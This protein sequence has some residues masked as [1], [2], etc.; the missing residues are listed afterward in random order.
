MLQFCEKTRLDGVPLMVVA[1]NLGYTDTRM[2]EKHYGHLAPR[3]CDAVRAG[4]PKFGIKPEKTN[5]K[6]LR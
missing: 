1:K 6:A 5:A 4:A 2:V 3:I